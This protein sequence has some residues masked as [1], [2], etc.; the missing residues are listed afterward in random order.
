MIIGVD[1][2]CWANGRGYGRFARE[3]MRAMTRQA[4]GDEFVCFG[5][6]R[7]FASYPDPEPNVRLVEVGLDESPTVAAAA[8]SSRSLRDLLRLT[9]AVSREKLDGFFSPSVYT[10]FPLPP[11]LPAVVTIHDTIPERFPALT[12]PS[13]RAR[14]FWTLKVRFALSQARLVLTVSEYSARSIA[15]VLRVPANRISAK[16]RTLPAA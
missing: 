2:T 1:A 14:L 13:A 3:L 8:D 10:F 15:S 12:L 6:Q 4:P 7:S 16:R 9:R 5:D 11:R